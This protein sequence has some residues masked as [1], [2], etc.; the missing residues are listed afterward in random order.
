[1]RQFNRKHDTIFWYSK[2]ANWVFDKDA[3]RIDYKDGTPHAGGFKAAKVSIQDEKYSKRGKVP[4]THW[5]F[6]IAARGKEYVG[7]PTQKPLKLLERIISASSNKDDL[8]LDPFCGCATT[9]VAA[10]GIRTKMG[11]YRCIYQSL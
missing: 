7:Y 4:E 2:S 5:A 8:V 10:E 1:M 9:C 11:R 6:A 3:V